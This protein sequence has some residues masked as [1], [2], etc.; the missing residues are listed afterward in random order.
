MF[1]CVWFD[2]NI[3]PFDKRNASSGNDLVPVRYV[4]FVALGVVE[5]AN[6]ME[7]VQLWTSL[8]TTYRCEN[9]SHSASPNSTCRLYY[10]WVHCK[11]WF[12]A[13]GRNIWHKD[14]PET[15]SAIYHRM[16]FLCSDRND[17][18]CECQCRVCIG[19][20]L[21]PGSFSVAMTRAL[22]LMPILEQRCDHLMVRDVPR[23]LFF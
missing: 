9:P 20:R 10:S 6:S 7:T 19:V 5:I 21:E 17:T 4:G 14:W 11:E 23:R 1:I 12:H 2:C 3:E 18:P 15:R 22:L 8:G 16:S 13:M